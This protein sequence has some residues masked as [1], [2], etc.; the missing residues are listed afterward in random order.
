MS[1]TV[2]FPIKARL[3]W[4][5]VFDY[6]NSGNQGSIEH[7]YTFTES[8]SYTSTEFNESVAT[9][10][11]KL[12]DED[13]IEVQVGASYGPVSANVGAGHTSSKEI[14]DMLQNTSRIQSES[15]ISYSRTEE[16]T[17]TVGPQSRLCLYQRNFKYPGMSVA[18]TT[19]RTTPVPLGNDELEEEVVVD[20][21]LAP[22]SFIKNIKAC[23]L[24]PRTV[25]ASESM[26]SW[27][28]QVIYS[29][30]LTQAP[31][32]RIRDINGGSDDINYDQ[33]GKYVWL[34][35]E[36]TTKVAE[37]ITHIDLVITSTED[38][39]YDDLAKGAKGKY[40][41]LI[42]IRQS[43]QSLFL[44][45][46]RLLRSHSDIINIGIIIGLFQAS[47][48]TKDINAGRGGDYLHLLWDS[49]RAYPIN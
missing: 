23:F 48:Y 12:H 47:G 3:L 33:S 46:L 37:A 27:F 43:G 8:G 26:F 29:D 7:K 21:V 42:P 9:H 30:R 15:T 31:S 25:H 4:R 5:L 28:L 18:E 44:T 34:V 24:A 35:A 40:R 39:R 6:D 13:K 19:F 20:L 36:K 11:K 16:R 41:Y 45:N 2:A 1:Q 10:A 22:K 14:D 17:Y 49:E 38:K 32:D